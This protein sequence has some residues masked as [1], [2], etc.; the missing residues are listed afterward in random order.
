MHLLIALTLIYSNTM[1]AF[2]RGNSPIEEIVKVKREKDCVRDLIIA[3]KTKQEIFS[4]LQR[5]LVFLY[6]ELGRRKECMFVEDTWFTYLSLID[7]IYRYAREVRNT[8]DTI[9]KLSL[10]HI[11]EPTRPY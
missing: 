8:G 1:F 2:S 9:I 11:S 7:D 3:F 10:I 4:D 6:M 5:E